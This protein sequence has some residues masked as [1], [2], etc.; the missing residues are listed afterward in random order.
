MPSNNCLHSLKLAAIPLAVAIAS[1]AVADVPEYTRTTIDSNLAGAAFVIAGNVADNPRPEIIVSAFGEFQFGP[2]GPVWPDAGKVVMYKNAQK[3]N[4]PNGQIENWNVTEIVSEEDEIRVPNRPTLADVNG[5]GKL[6][7]IVAAGYF[8]DTFIGNELGSITWWE[9]RANGKEWVR[10]DVV[11]ESPFSYHSAVFEDV[12]GDGI[13]DIVSVGEDAGN[14]QSADDDIVELQMFK[15]NGDGT[16]QPA[17][18]L[19]DGGGGLIEAYDVNGDGRMDIVSP[20]Y[21]GPVAGQPFVPSFARDASVASYVWFENTE[22]NGFQRHAIGTNQG[23]GFAIVPVS[24]LR[25]DGV[26][27]WVATNHTNDTIPFPP[28][29]LYPEP[30]VYEFTPGIDP[31]QPWEVRQLSTSGS[32]PVTGGVGQSA[33]GTAAVADLNSD[34]KLDIAV[35]GDGSRAVYWLEQQEDGSFVTHQFPD[36]TGYGQAGGPVTIDLNRSG[37]KE[38]IFGSF[39]Q[40]S[41]SIWGR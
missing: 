8:F 17:Y 16:F 23:T 35:S 5:D 6:D 3:G 26:V 20:Q 41:V 40:N 2:Y 13:E 15:G 33:P 11:T 7:V 34:G 32:F 12:D 4:K 30:A 25:G 27:R 18:K 31:T 10:H 28:F 9:N 39:D 24:N 37:K 1:H 36:S 19:A 38:V 29:A 21:F 22:F 14:P